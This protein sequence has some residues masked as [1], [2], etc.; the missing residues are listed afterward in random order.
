[1]LRVKLYGVASSH[2]RRSDQSPQPRRSDQSP[3]PR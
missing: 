3:Q 2:L 1:M